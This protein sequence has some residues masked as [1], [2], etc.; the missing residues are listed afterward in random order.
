VLE[1]HQEDGTLLWTPGVP[2]E[3]LPDIASGHDVFLHAFSGSMDKAA[4]EAAASGLPVLSENASVRR[5]IGAW[6]GPVDLA[7]QLLSFVQA[8]PEA[9]AAFSRSQQDRVR[10]K[11]SLDSLATRL[12]DVIYPS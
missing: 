2:R 7:A 1:R 10:A 3:Q 12:L 11:H 8:D 4:L 5:E 9:R 6:P